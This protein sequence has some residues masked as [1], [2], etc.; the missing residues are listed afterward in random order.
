MSAAKYVITAVDKPGSKARYRS[1]LRLL[2]A[3]SIRIE[4]VAHEPEQPRPKPDNLPTTAESK[5]V[6]DLY[7][8]KHSTPWADKEIA[9]FRKAVAAGLTVESMAVIAAYYAKERRKDTHYCRRD[10]FTFL[11]NFSTELDRA[12][13]AKPERAKALEWAPT[14]VVPMP[15][16]SEEARLAGIEALRRTRAEINGGQA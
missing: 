16:L 14:N 7:G 6:A 1:A 12:R 9:A 4:E 13:A 15:E 10:L 5:A 2:G 8:R 3:E 11:G